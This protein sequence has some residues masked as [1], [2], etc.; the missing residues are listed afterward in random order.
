[1][2]KKLLII[3]LSSMGDIAQA[4]SMVGRI[5]ESEPSCDLH[6]LV[7]SDMVD[8]PSMHSGID[9]IWSLDRCDGLTGIFRLARELKHQRFTHI[10]DAHL[11]IRSV[12]FLFALLFDW[13]NLISPPKIIIR[14][15]NRIKRFLLFRFR[16]NRFTNWPFIGARSYLDPLQQVGVDSKLPLTPAT[17][18]QDLRQ[19]MLGR[20]KGE[21]ITPGHFVALVPGAAWPLKQWPL[22]YWKRLVD[23]HPDTHFVVLG[24]PDDQM[25]RELS[26]N[27][28]DKIFNLAGKLTIKESCAVVQLAAVT[29]V[30]DTGLLHVADLFGARAIALIGPTA[31]GFPAGKWIDIVEHKMDCRPCTKDGRGA[32]PNPTPAECMFAITPE[33]ISSRLQMVDGL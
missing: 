16:I 3:R 13:R 14:S 21:G 24:G 1:M 8:L 5:K 23:L 31:F 4:M 32:C 12:I 9:Q 28:P 22:D 25:S 6:W 19:E 10:Y 29:V 26:E 7:R 11:V 17:F 27:F 15:K 18:P 33:E 20:L 30:A 2:I